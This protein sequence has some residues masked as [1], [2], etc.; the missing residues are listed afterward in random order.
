MITS[1]P[2]NRKYKPDNKHEDDQKYLDTMNT[3]YLEVAWH[4]GQQL[5]VQWKRSTSTCGLHVL[6]RMW[7][8]GLSHSS[9]HHFT[10]YKVLQKKKGTNTADLMCSDFHHSAV[11]LR[12]WPICNID[13]R[14]HPKGYGS[15]TG[16]I[17]LIHPTQ[18]EVSLE[19]KKK[20]KKTPFY[21]DSRISNVMFCGFY[22][23]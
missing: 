21:F 6:G 22:C 5:H 3:M 12:G 17:F 8:L 7:Y 13:D 15:T 2:T 19:K 4:A 16:S 10:D 14:S 23:R 1:R 11:F 20:K 9:P 18:V